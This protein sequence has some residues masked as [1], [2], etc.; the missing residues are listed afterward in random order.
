MRNSRKQQGGVMRLCI[1]MVPAVLS[2]LMAVAATP[3]RGFA[4][5]GVA[6]TL[7]GTV[8]DSSGAV[9][10]GAAITARN[11]ATASTSTAVSGADGLFTIP[12]LE[13]GNYKVTVT[14]QG[15]TTVALDDIRLNAGVPTNIK[16][17]LTPGGITETVVVEGAIE[18]LA[19]TQTSVST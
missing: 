17:V 9:V 15:F 2:L 11:K 1:F 5:G 6:A 13:P 8:F 19:T 10:P 3:R 4:Q 12:A 14:M 18:L 7:S 16:P